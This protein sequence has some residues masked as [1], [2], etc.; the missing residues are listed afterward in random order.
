MPDQ[1]FFKLNL[2]ICAAIF[3]S[4]CVSQLEPLPRDSSIRVSITPGA[5]R[6]EGLNYDGTL[7]ENVATG[8]GLG[9]TV[10]SLVA[11]AACGPWFVLCA[12]GGSLI[13]AVTGAAAGGL[14]GVATAIDGE[15]RSGF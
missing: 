8:A 14:Y 4:S 9:M 6:S 7:S 11:V 5:D 2:F 3:L 10:G 12:A 15:I 1:R 13:G